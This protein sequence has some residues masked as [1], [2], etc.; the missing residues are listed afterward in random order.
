K[1]EKQQYFSQ[2]TAVLVVIIDLLFQLCFCSAFPLLY[3]TWEQPSAGML[4]LFLLY[5]NPSGLS[6][7]R[8]DFLC[9]SGLTVFG[10]I[11]YNNNQSALERVHSMYSAV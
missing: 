10:R 1:V 6:R 11:C 8:P 3:L 4:F 9:I 7:G 5:L 2:N